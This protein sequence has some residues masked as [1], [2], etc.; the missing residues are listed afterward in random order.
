MV[1]LVLKVSAGWW[2]RWW[3]YQLYQPTVDGGAVTPGPG[4]GIGGGGAM[5]YAHPV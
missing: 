4:G 3:C 5:V 1:E 2:W